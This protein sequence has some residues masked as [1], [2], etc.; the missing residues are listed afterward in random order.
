MTTKTKQIS[1]SKLL[2]NPPIF[3]PSE[4]LPTHT[5]AIRTTEEALIAH[6]NDFIIGLDLETT[7]LHHWTDEIRVVQLYGY[8][9]NKLSILHYP[10]GTLPLELRKF[11]STRTDTVWIGQ[12]I[13]T[14]DARFLHAAGVDVLAI[15]MWD[16]LLIEGIINAAYRRESDGIKNDLQSLINR[17]LNIF[18]PKQVD[19]TTWQDGLFR[20][21]SE[22]QLKY[23]AD[24]VRFL[25]NLMHMQIK[26]LRNAATRKAS[27]F[28]LNVAKPVIQMS[29]RGLPVD[30]DRFRTFIYDNLKLLHAA[31]EELREDFPGNPDSS[32]QILDFLQGKGYQLAS[33]DAPTLRAYLR[34]HPNDILLPKI[35]SY[36]KYSKSNKM[37]NPRWFTKY[38]TR[39]GTVASSYTQ[40]STGTYRTSSRNPN[41]QNYPINIRQ[42]FGHPTEWMVIADY[43]TVEMRVAAVL[44]QDPVMLD[45]FINDLDIHHRTAASLFDKIE[46]DVTK[47]ERQAAKASN[48]AMIFGGG[49][50]SIIR[51]AEQM[52]LHPITV[53]EAEQMKAAFF[54]LY[55]TMANV[56]KVLNVNLIRGAPV[57]P[58]DQ[59]L[60][61]HLRQY[62]DNS[63]GNAFT[64]KI[65]M[66]PENPNA[67]FGHTRTL[68]DDDIKITTA[69]N[70][71]IQ[72]TAAIGI[73]TALLRIMIDY[74]ELL[75]YLAG[76]VHD[77][78]ILTGYKSEDEANE[79][80]VKLSDAMLRG[81]QQVCPGVKYAVES[82]VV[83]YW[84]EAK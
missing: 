24:D 55:T 80:S 21:L 61:E 68:Y 34:E 13:I 45:A 10:D 27:V 53:P 19:H 75:P 58:E 39:T 78:I 33:T 64:I 12:N 38:L 7:G 54:R 66:N 26:T 57:K 72:G 31:R 5:D 74:P 59:L 79:A 71:P 49:P 14:F 84:D 83:H 1:W 52:E 73:K 37:Y 15:N 20:E 63:R 22:E 60:L 51:K 4:N 77:E 43:S 8:P 9:S 65:G 44:T 28:E 6:E 2:D 40:T 42:V 76:T 36:R 3:I 47:D 32:T 81:M 29:I 41:A 25:T 23:A 18:I 69:L 46:T 50:E 30:R 17:H 35:L 56:H 82:H 11:I 48:F 62:Y 70:T 16:T 67:F